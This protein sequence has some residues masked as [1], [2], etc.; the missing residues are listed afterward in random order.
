VSKDKKQLSILKIIIYLNLTYEI[1]IFALQICSQSDTRCAERQGLTEKKK[2]E[3]E[4][5]GKNK[6]KEE[7]ERK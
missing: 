6:E 2:G 1:L 5:N 7:E 3:L 4:N